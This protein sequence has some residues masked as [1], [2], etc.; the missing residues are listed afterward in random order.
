[1]LLLGFAT[2]LLL[3]RTVLNPLRGIIRSLV[4]IGD[5]GDLS[6]RVSVVGSGEITELAAAFNQMLDKLEQTQ[7]QL[8]KNEELYRG[9]VEDQTELIC[10][11]LPDGTITFVNDAYSR[12]HNAR[13]EALLGLNV[14]AF[15]R[16]SRWTSLPRTWE[17]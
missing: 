8:K 4:S 14:Y 11:F 9:V 2:L 3:K 13:P 12:Y 7:E 6:R 10:R 1:M 15:I 17:P 5:S 16:R